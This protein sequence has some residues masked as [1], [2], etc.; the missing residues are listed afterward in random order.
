MHKALFLA[1][2]AVVFLLSQPALPQDTGE[3]EIPDD[4]KGDLKEKKCPEGTVPD[5]KGW[6]VKVKPGTDQPPVK[7]AADETPAEGEKPAVEP[8]APQPEEKTVEKPA[9]K[10]ATRPELVPPGAKPEVPATAAEPE[11]PPV[12]PEAPAATEDPA[13]QPEKPEAPASAAAAEEQPEKTEVSEGEAEEEQEEEDKSAK[14]VKGELADFIGSNKL[15][16]ENNRIGVRLGYR[17]IDMAHYL[18]INPEAD[19]RIWKFQFGLGVPMAI[20]IFDGAWDEAK[21]E[22]VGF[23]DVGDFRTED[24]NEPGEYVRWIR[25]LTFGKKEDHIYFNLSQYN[26]NTI[27]H[28]PLMR[29]Y[30][31]NI[32]PDS[33][34]L[35]F[36]LDMYN[37]YAGFELMGNSVVDWDLFGAIAF[38]KPLSFFTEN[39]MARSLSI[40][41]TYLADRHAPVS[42]K[43]KTDPSDN[44]FYIVGSGQPEVESSAFLHALGVDMEIKVLKTEHVDLKPF[45]DYSWFMPQTPNG[46]NPEEPEGGGGFTAG[47]LGRF[48]FGSDPVHALRAIAEFRS[49]SS[50][51]LPGYFDSFYEVQKFVAN[52]RYK[53][54]GQDLNSLPPTKFT[55]VFVE[56]K[57]GDRHLGFY[58]ELTYSLV[59][60]LALTLAIEGSDADSGNNML[61]H[62]EFNVFDWLQL[63]AS[64]H[65]RAMDSLGDLFSSGGGNRIVFAAA[66]AKVVPFIF[67]NFRYHYTFELHEDFADLT[68]DGLEQRYRF[69]EAMHGWMADIEFGWEF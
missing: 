49:F 21:G 68:G 28:G 13:E 16:T 37:D 43:T 34:K 58:F 4:L 52:T 36:E 69:Y 18:T 42:L 2:F 23:D 56:R 57:G 39:D 22:P 48:N 12:K 31:V 17:K 67:L 5:E 11:E 62:A 41:V 19:F 46:D 38:V 45:V 15:V 54:Y 1:S 7:P 44:P 24:W 63:F 8:S 10:P 61:A 29:R 20:E 14:F 60:Y 27:G 26:S 9:D 51:Y 30:S 25:Y 55:D 6:C 65:H 40:G 53:A 59:D 64:Y 66:R 3:W 47:I 35:S 50:N 33:T 32:D